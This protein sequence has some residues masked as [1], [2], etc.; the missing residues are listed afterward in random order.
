MNDRIVYTNPDG[1]CAVVVPAPNSGLTIDE[2]M[3]KD[4]PAGAINPRKITTA[5][6][7]ADRL[8]RG[9]WD[10]SNPEDF[11][12]TDLVK[13]KEIAH[14]MRRAKRQEQL[15]PLD[16]ESGF[17]STTPQRAAQITTEKQAIL[18]ANA[19][20]QTDIDGCADE[21]ALR[22]TLTGAGVI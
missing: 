10:D 18:A 19:T 21:A 6:L 5:E 12:G 3:A 20:V 17:V 4:V 2:I 22:S 16:E 13:A 11:I 15:A 1:S 14:G 9:A 7:P 8:F